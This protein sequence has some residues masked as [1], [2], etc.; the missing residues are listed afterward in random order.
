MDHIY[1]LL[2]GLKI[3]NTKN[4]KNN[5]CFQYTINVQWYNMQLSRL[6]LYP[7][8]KK[9]KKYTSKKKNISQEMELSNPKIKKILLFLQKKIFLHFRKHNFLRDNS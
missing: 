7:R 8:S 2:T 5:K 4:E 3:K 6:L 9:Y 1:T